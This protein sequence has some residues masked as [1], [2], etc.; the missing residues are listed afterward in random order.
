LGVKEVR[1]MARTRITR[2]FG[3]R[4]NGKYNQKVE[5]GSIALHADSFLQAGWRVAETRPDGSVFVESDGSRYLLE[6]E[7][8]EDLQIEE[9]EDYPE[10][11]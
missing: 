2:V 7:N 11:P 1:T 10:I 8:V 9:T 6:S 3:A 4:I 5:P